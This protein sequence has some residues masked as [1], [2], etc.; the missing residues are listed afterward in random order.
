MG[1]KDNC[2]P[3]Q[4]TFPPSLLIQ[5]QQKSWRTPAD[6]TVGDVNG[7]LL[8]HK[9]CILAP[10]SLLTPSRRMPCRLRRG[11][12][13][14]SLCGADTRGQRCPR[15][16]HSCTTGRC[17]QSGQRWAAGAGGD[18]SSPC[19]GDP[20]SSPQAG[21]CGEETRCSTEQHNKCLV[22]LKAAPARTV[23][24]WSDWYRKVL[25]LGVVKR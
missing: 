18:L 8:C 23:L 4:L 12:V 9:Y 16:G 20:C 1:W 5:G 7:L 3:A 10:A 25:I 17:G 22:D 11:W 15:H 14:S 21:P 19:V 24:S 13:G 6:L 2:W